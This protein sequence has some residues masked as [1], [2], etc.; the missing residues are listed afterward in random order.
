MLVLVFR[1]PDEPLVPTSAREVC[2]LDESLKKKS[3]KCDVLLSDF[4]TICVSNHA[5]SGPFEYAGN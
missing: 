1:F 4:T 5:T 2:D 3:V